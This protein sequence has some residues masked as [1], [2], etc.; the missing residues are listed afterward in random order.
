MIS[1]GIAP[2]SELAADS[3]LRVGTRGGVIVDDQL[4][5]EDERIFAIGECALLNGRIYGLAAP[6]YAMAKHVA[7]R[8]AGE[9]TTSFPKPDLSTRLKMLGIDV[10]TIGDP[11]E[12]GRRIEFESDE[13]YRML[14]VSPRN[15]LLGGLGVGDWP[16]SGRIQG[17]FADGATIRPNE[18]SYFVEEGVLSGEET[19]LD[20]GALPDKRII[21]NCMNITK[22]E[23]VTCLAKCGPDPDKLASETGAS[24]VCG[25]CRPLVD[26]LC[27][28][29]PSTAKPVAYRAMLS[30]SFVALLAVLVTYFM[31]GVEM[32]NSVESWRYKV[33]QFW[34]DNVVKQITGF[35]LLAVAILGTLISLRKRF[36]WFRF[37]HFAKWRVFHAAFG[38]TSLVVLFMHTGFHFGHNLNF[39]LMFTFVGLNLLGAFAG[40]VSA[41]ES[42][43]TSNLAL[44]ARQIRPALTYAH[45]VLFWPL[46]VLLTFHILSVYLY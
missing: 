17:L 21:C 31:P 30:V 11:L 20:I 9:K 24:T 8:I 5:T 3:E 10:V 6:G 16:E 18:Q 25:S 26:Q 22:G 12:E 13:H 1:A 46:P 36:T 33:E 41:I 15:Q 45:L 4:Q 29:A 43:G 14:V 35:V 42:S 39:W 44:F 19:T 27:G 2:N 32:A 23:L 38:I 40:V 34:R 37:G 28:A 7:K